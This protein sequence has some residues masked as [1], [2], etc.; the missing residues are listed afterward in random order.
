MAAPLKDRTVLIVGR[1]GGIARAA[2]ESAREAGARVVAAGRN[3]A[4]LESVYGGANITDEYVDLTDEASINA[5]GERLG[6]VD[7]VVSAASAR[8]KGRLADL[9]R[10]AV[11]MAFDERSSG[12]SCWPSTSDRACPRTGR[13]S[14]SRAT[15]RSSHPSA[16]WPSP[17]RTAPWTV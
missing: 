12:R 17:G 13:S 10:E 15:Q 3:Q 7:H 1:A 2:A 9:D 5:L 14:S 8:A 4:A 11:R 6:T 16:S